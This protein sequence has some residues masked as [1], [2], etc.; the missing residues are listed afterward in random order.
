MLHHVY[1]IH[2]S[3]GFYISSLRVPEYTVNLDLP[4]AQRWAEI[5]KAKKNEVGSVFPLINCLCFDKKSGLVYLFRLITCK[6]T[7]KIPCDG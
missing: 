2:R 7:K 3:T 6:Y 5:G 4:P 1:F